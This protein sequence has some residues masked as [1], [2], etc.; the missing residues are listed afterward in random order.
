MANIPPTAVKGSSV[1]SVVAGGLGA[2]VRTLGNSKQRSR[3]T[4]GLMAG[5]GAFLRAM[6]KAAHMLWLEVTGFLFVCF[7]VIGSFATI[8]EYRAFAAG[9]IPIGRT[10]MGVCF[11][12]MFAYFGISSFMRARRK[13]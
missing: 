7:A 6:A 9:K 8:R 13:S 3:M 11:T 12:L 2:A 4:R 5:G 1:G 10:V